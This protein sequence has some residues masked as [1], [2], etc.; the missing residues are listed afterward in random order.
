MSDDALIAD[1]RRWR[2]IATRLSRLMLTRAP[3]LNGLDIIEGVEELRQFPLCV[4]ESADAAVDRLIDLTGKGVTMSV[5]KAVNILREVRDTLELEQSEQADAEAL[6]FA[7]EA[8]EREGAPQQWALK[9]VDE[10]IRL[11]KPHMGY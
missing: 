10:A 7:D 4:K 6:R 8:E 5:E 9:K 11:L 1:A 2:F 3:P